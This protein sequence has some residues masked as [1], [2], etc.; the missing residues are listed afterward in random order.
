M[1]ITNFEKDLAD[2]MYEVAKVNQADGKETKD[3]IDALAGAIAKIVE[4]KIK[5]VTITLP[6]ASVNV[7]GTVAGAP[8]TMTN[9]LPIVLNNV[10]T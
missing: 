5:S 1:A 8:A 10:V 2:A 4:E 7:A 6:S 9:T 3:A